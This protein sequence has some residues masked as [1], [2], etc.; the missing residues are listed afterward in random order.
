MATVGVR[1]LAITHE[2]LLNAREVAVRSRSLVPVFFLFLK[3]N[4]THISDKKN[5]LG[6]VARIVL[7]AN[8]G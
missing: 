5:K 3:L 4:L 6:R 2:K 1:Q 7:F 8:K